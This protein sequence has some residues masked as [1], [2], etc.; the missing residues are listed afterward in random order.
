MTSCW[1]DRAAPRH[2][3]ADRAGKPGGRRRHQPSL[4]VDVVRLHRQLR[5]RRRAM[6]CPGTTRLPRGHR[7]HLHG[8][9]AQRR[10]DLRVPRPGLR[11]RRQLL[12][13]HGLRQ[14]EDHHDTTP[15]PTGDIRFAP[16]IDITMP[17]PS[18][19]GAAARDRGEE[20]HAGL[21]TGRQHAAATRP[22]AGSSPSPTRGSST[23]SRRSRPRA[24][25][26]SSRAAAPRAVPGAQL[27]HHRHPA[28]RLQEGARH[29]RH[30]PAGR[31]HRGVIDVNKV[32][33]AL[34]QLQT[35]RGTVVQVHA[36]GA[37]HRT[38]G[39][40]RSRCRSSR[41]PPPRA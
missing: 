38:T 1:T 26:W 15:P 24:A 40:T 41:T 20:L 12:G 16:Y 39:S 23:T 2:P 37:G 21:R 18:L 35:E 30:E 34:K 33:S 14:R 13:V 4:T 6:R 31:R 28:R 25:R 7:D 8:H 11:R 17:T 32:N 36:A 19:T 3:G 10:H 22:G 27:R 5:Q 9:R 29:G